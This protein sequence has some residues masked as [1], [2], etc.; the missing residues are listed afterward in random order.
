MFEE[1]GDRAWPRA[2]RFYREQWL[3]FNR[4]LRKYFLLALTVFLV[5]SVAGFVFYA[6]RP[7]RAGRDVKALAER[8]AGGLPPDA[9]PGWLFLHLFWNNFRAAAL[10]AALGIIPFL[11]LPMIGAAANGTALGLV[12]AFAGQAESLGA[13]KLAAGILPHGILELPA[14]WLAEAL[15]IFLCVEIGRRIR[16]PRRQSVV[17]LADSTG[18]GSPDSAVP[19]D[20]RDDVFLGDLVVTFGAVVVPM[21]LV[22]AAVEAFVTPFVL[23]RLG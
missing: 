2:K 3:F 19:A 1:F 16:R 6:A 20:P 14:V 8:L 22:A 18:L 5:F 23:G 21:L 17:G 11:F 12:A 9:S 15:G 13:G 7:E 4:F 10:G